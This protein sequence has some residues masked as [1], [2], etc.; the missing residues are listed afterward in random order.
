M[1]KK[2]FTDIFFFATDNKNVLSVIRWKKVI[3]P[4]GIYDKNRLS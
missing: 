2:L 1:H 4:C 3:T